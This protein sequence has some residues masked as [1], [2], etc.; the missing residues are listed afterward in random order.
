MPK[1]EEKFNSGIDITEIATAVAKELRRLSQEDKE[2]EKKENK[3][4]DFYCFECNAKVKPYQKYCGECQ[5][6]LVWED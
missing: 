4:E 5:A 6:E 1:E 2:K 3:E